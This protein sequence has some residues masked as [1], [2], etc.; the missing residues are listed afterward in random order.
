M[1]K[2]IKTYEE[3]DAIGKHL[4]KEFANGIKSRVLI[5]PSKEY[6]AK[7]KARAE[8]EAQRQAEEEEKQAIRK[9]IADKEKA[10]AIKELLEKGEITQA[11]LDKIS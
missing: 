6:A 5:E 10:I 8:A 2:I 3:T 9:K 1:P 11:E 4:V 7:M